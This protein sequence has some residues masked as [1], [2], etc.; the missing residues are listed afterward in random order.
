MDICYKFKNRQSF[1]L[2]V[3]SSKLVISQDPGLE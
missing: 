2:A 1:D 3:D